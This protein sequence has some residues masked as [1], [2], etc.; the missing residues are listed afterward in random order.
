MSFPVKTRHLFN[1]HFFLN[2]LLRSSHQVS[3]L[4]LIYLQYITLAIA[5]GNS[6]N[7]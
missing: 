6:R 1:A 4:S 3:T 5:S 2:S 7:I